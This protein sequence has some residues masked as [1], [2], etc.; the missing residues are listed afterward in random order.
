V[1]NFE[2][3]VTRLVAESA[4]RNTIYRYAVSIDEFNETGVRSVFCHDAVATYW[5]HPRLKGGDASR[6]S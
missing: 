2:Q 1:S 6:S 4:V 5:N 3:D